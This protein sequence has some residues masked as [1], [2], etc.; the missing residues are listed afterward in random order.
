MILIFLACAGLVLKLEISGPNSGQFIIQSG[1]GFFG[2]RELSD[3]YCSYSGVKRVS[4]RA[5]AGREL[6]RGTWRLTRHNLAVIRDS[7]SWFTMVSYTRAWCILRLKVGVSRCFYDKLNICHI[8][9][10]GAGLFNQGS[11]KVWGQGGSNTW[12]S[13]GC[14][15]ISY[16]KWG[17][18]T[19]FYDFQKVYSLQTCELR[20]DGD[21]PGTGS[22][23]GGCPQGH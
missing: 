8:I 7:V 4:T 6:S 13:L 1:Y 3:Q 22:Q 21:P 19:N 15:I 10:V 14:N 2:S 16:L 18:I 23:Q 11:K 20:L 5:W 17:Y 9:G 12:S